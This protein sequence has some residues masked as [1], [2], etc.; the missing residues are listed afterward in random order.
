M[1]YQVK[2]IPISLLNIRIVFASQI[3]I[4]IQ[5]NGMELSFIYILKLG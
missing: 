4:I 1:L 5:Y 3:I 2:S